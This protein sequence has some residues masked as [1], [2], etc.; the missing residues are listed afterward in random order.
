M[1]KKAKATRTGI[2]KKSAIQWKEYRSV[3]KIT[4]KQVARLTPIC[5]GFRREYRKYMHTSDGVVINFQSIDFLVRHQPERFI[6]IMRSLFEVQK[7]PPDRA[8]LPFLLDF[9]KS[10]GK[11]HTNYFVSGYQGAIVGDTKWYGRQLVRDVLILLDA[12]HGRIKLPSQM[13]KDMMA[14]VLRYIESRY[15]S[16]RLTADIAAIETFA[17]HLIKQFQKDQAK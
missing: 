7:C 11:R 14:E 17:A 4:W 2:R 9:W 8:M 10:F 6:R 12:M 5:N 3:P 16:W 1:A 13:K 15:Y